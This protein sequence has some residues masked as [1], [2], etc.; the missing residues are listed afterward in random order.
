MASVYSSNSYDSYTRAVIDQNANWYSVFAVSDLIRFFG[1][2]N[3]STASARAVALGKLTSLNVAKPY[4][5]QDGSDMNPANLRFSTTTP[6]G[7]PL[8]SRVF[9]AG[10]ADGWAEIFMAF[11]N[12]LNFK[13]R[14]AEKTLLSNDDQNGAVESISTPDPGAYRSQFN[15]ASQAFRGATINAA[16]MLRNSIGVYNFRK[17]EDKYNLIWSV[18]PEGVTDVDD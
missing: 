4:S 1:T 16:L 7:A 3:F 6:T 5:I 13:D 9:L 8:I 2:V 17:F 11:M 15:D 10:F 18:T 14:M 12:S